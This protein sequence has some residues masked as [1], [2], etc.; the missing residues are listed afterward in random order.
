M[1]YKLSSTL[2][3]HEQDVKDVAITENGGLVSVLRDGTTRIWS[4]IYTTQSEATI[5]FQSPTNSFINSVAS[6]NDLIASGGQDAMIYLSDE[7]GDDKY[8]LIGHEGNVCSMSYSHGQLIS[9][10]WDCTAIVWNLEEFI[11]KYILSG[12]ESS[13]WDCQVLGED[14]YLT[15]GA[16]K[17]IRLW[18]GKSEVKQFIGHLD[19]IRKLL[20]L[21]GGKQFLS[22]SND[23]SI[24]LWDLQ[25]GK[26]L[27]TFY[28]HDS[29]VYDLAWIANDRFVSTGED[30]TARVWDLAT[31]NVL[32][33]ITLPCISIW[34]VAA[35][36]NGDFA[37]GGSDNLIR[38]FTAD[39]ERVAPEE[40]LLKFKEAVQSS[41]IAEQSLDD[42]KKTDIPGYEALSQPG[43]QE[44]STIMVKNPNSG[45]I[46]AH[47]W[48]GGE[49]HKI[50]DVVGSSSSG[51]KQTYQGKE[52]DFVFDV[53]IKDGEPPL[54][55]PYNVNDNPY[56]AAEKFLGDNNLPASYTDEVVRFLQKNTEGVSLQESSNN[57]NNISDERV[58]D[59]Y[60]D[61]YNRQQQQQQQQQL[62]SALKVIPSKSYIYFTDYKTGLLVNGLKKLNLSQD[63]EV[64]LSDQDLSVVESSLL[65]LKSKEALD[66]ITRYCSHIIRKWT[67]SAKLIGFDLLRVSI[68]KVTTVDIL[69]STD[70]AEV[71]LDVVN[72]GFENINVENPA[73][74]MMILKVLNNLVG[75]T[76]FVQLYIDPCGTDN[77]LYEYNTFFKNLLKKLQNNTVKLT[78]LAKLYTSTITALT[79][80]V[81]NLSAYQLQTSALKNNIESSKPVIEFM[82]N[83]GHQIVASSSE[84]AYRLA[85]AYGNF[86]YGELYTK[87][88]PSWLAEVGILYAI[89]GEQRFL[90]IAED[91]KNI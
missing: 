75:T 28:G 30:R 78:Q 43:K 71:I 20:I 73:L 91:L 70:A 52:Y 66:L 54:K 21:E 34:C 1:S 24:K 50:G 61:A 17:T 51:K 38:V 2:F 13:V 16:D 18:Q 6:F 58:I 87:E 4:D 29:F 25:T 84:A 76:L 15:C 53:D 8:Q 47:Q 41:S 12:H 79:T 7:H 46:E 86:K 33:V 69:T 55:L 35:L 45:T 42:L 31:G 89:N 44:G 80:L 36:P 49:W 27:Q 68:P 37:V 90:D 63:T 65:D 9:S 32:Q 26:N 81:Y 10:S 5:L 62:K 67:A 60:S 3:G 83:L 72:L 48:S 19:V 56:T 22:C 39:P 64:Q 11:P 59:P 77:K 57:S 88:T 82:D 23:G 14:Q 85:V 74:L 40:E